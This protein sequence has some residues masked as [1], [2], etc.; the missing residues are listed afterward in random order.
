M[1]NPSPRVHA[2]DVGDVRPCVVIDDALLDPSS[3]VEIAV[4]HREAFSQPLTHAYPG[5]ELP[6]PE[7]VVQRFV[8]QFGNH[9][10]SLLGVDRIVKAQGRLS[11]ATLQPEELTSLQRIC[12]RDR[13][14]V[15]AG[16]C[17]IA[18]VLY[19]FSDES[20]GGTSFFRTLRGREETEALIQQLARNDE[21]SRHLLRGQ[22]PGYLT[23]SNEYFELTATVSPKWNRLIWY[24]GSIF[25]GSHITDPSKLSDDPA[26]GRLTLNLFLQGLSKAA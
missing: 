7:S 6:L 20:L 2:V 18:A 17:A 25:H 1:L 12:H 4:A 15:G 8:E 19:L 3:L 5:V 14:F 16:E 26:T 10:A 22:P 23:G 13:L 24:D 11:V 9:A 21:K